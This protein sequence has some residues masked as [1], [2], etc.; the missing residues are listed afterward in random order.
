M[1]ANGT[2]QVRL[3]P[4]PPFDEADGVSL[5]RVNLDKTFS[6]P[7]EGTSVGQMIAARTTI[8]N[9]AGYVAIER[10]TGSLDGKRGSFVMQH[11]GIMDR[12]TASLLVNIVPDSGTGELRGLSGTMDIRIENG[13]H[14]YELEY[15]FAPI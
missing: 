3:Q 1:K 11:R 12:G 14:F 4:E 5:G 8:A 13:T 7:L 15:T 6:G 2:F 9:S 10:M